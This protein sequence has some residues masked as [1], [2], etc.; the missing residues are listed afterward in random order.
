[1]TQTFDPGSLTRALPATDADYLG[2]AFTGGD[3][4][5]LEEL[6]PCGNGG[7]VLWD[8]GMYV[9]VFVRLTLDRWVELVEFCALP[10]SG[11][12]ESVEEYE[13]RCTA[14][15]AHQTA[16]FAALPEEV[17]AEYRRLTG[18]HG[19]PGPGQ[20][21]RRVVAGLLGGGEKRPN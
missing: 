10:S 1:M 6:H 4:I 13:R 7:Y 5:P 8:N 21:I 9:E 3:P 20:G 2:E 12:S 11:D 19:F 14:E 15:E 16:A 17:R 18:G